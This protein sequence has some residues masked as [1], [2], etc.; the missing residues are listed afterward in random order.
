MYEC[1][2]FPGNSKKVPIL[3]A[4]WAVT[5]FFELKTAIFKRSLTNCF[6]NGN[7]ET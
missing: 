6:G 7:G 2:E 3:R 5:E 1:Y 4:K